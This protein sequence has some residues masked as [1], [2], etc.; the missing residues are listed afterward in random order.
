MR[1]YELGKNFGKAVVKAWETI[2]PGYRKYRELERRFTEIETKAARIQVL[3]TQLAEVQRTSKDISQQ[4]ETLARE[5]SEIENK[6]AQVN[7]DYAVLKENFSDYRDA[8]EKEIGK[9]LDQIRAQQ[10]WKR[11]A[12]GLREDYASTVADL[13][14]QV[15]PKEFA[16]VTNSKDLIIKVSKMAAKKLGYNEAELIGKNIYHFAKDYG[17]IRIK[18]KMQIGSNQTEPVELPGTEIRDSKG[19][20]VPMNLVIVPIF[21]NVSNAEDRIYAGSVVRFESK[22]EYKE[23]KRNEREEFA[24]EEQRSYAVIEGA[25]TLLNKILSK[26]STS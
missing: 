18:L 13:Y 25:K 19:K 5:K 9:L 12:A 7:L 4:N 20:F 10:H 3:E 16:I 24:K 2:N 8:R 14:F 1:I 22:A 23:R 15:H 21:D 26:K 11:K 6:L 17:R